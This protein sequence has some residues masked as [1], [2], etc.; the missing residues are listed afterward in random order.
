MSADRALKARAFSSMSGMLSERL[1]DGLAAAL[2]QRLQM[3]NTERHLLEKKELSKRET[4]F[5]VTTGRCCFEAKL[6]ERSSPSE[7]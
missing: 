4:I 6:K 2:A 1:D 5:L 7:A 3:P